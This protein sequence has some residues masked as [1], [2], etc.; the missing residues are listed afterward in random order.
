[1]VSKMRQD[2]KKLTQKKNFKINKQQQK[3]QNMFSLLLY[4]KLIGL[5]MKNGKKNLAIKIVN[6][7]LKKVKEESNFPINYIL[8]NV[9]NALKTSVEIR[10]VKVRR[11]FHLVPFPVKKERKTFLASKWIIASIKKIKKKKNF[12]KISYSS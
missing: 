9:F 6:G 1:M 4:K 2:I 7:A 12:R 5:I 10:K 8:Y 3:N 11:S